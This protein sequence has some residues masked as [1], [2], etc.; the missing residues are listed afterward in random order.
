L[1]DEVGL[2]AA[3]KGMMPCPGC[4]EPL[5]PEAVICVKCGYNMKLGRKMQT[6]KVGGD[7]QGG[8][9]HG[10]VAQDLMDKAAD[11]LEGDEEAEASKDKEGMPWWVYLVILIVLITAAAIM[12]NRRGSSTEESK[13]GK[14][15]S[16]EPSA[17]LIV[18]A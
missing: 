18:P 8:V 5:P 14:K 1:F 12:L 4:A 15:A 17:R 16:L 7:S 13:D 2:K 3:P 9:G 6:V 11:T 10:V